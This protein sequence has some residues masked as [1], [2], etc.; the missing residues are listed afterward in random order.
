MGAGSILLILA[1]LILVALFVARPLVQGERLG[2]GLD[3]ER[4]H[5]IAERERAL[6]ALLELDFDHQ[7]G[8]V[9]PEVYAEHRQTLM[10]QG[11]E[12]LKH[13]ERLESAP[14]KAVSP[15]NK[16]KRGRAGS[17][18]AELESMIA[19]RKQQVG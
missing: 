18:D 1:L 12:A 14:E 8:K 7:L 5:W 3:P 17:T 11:A 19:R 2:A 13:L 4:S 10:R 16:S 15:P 9:P 6:E